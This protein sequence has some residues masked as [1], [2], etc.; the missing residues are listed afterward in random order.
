MAHFGTP[1]L[2]VDLGSTE[3]TNKHGIDL[4]ARVV[5]E[6]GNEWVYVQANGAIVANDVVVVTSAFQADQIDT[7]NSATHHGAVAVSDKAFADN[8]YGWVQ[9]YGPC[10]INVGSSCAI[11]AVLNSTGTAGRVDDDATSGAEVIEGLRTTA[12][13]SS[14]AATAFASY[15]M[16]GVTL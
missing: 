14:N 16:L 5:D 6:T 7:T 3:S 13:E 12:A 10:T 15:P 4:G 2:G 9:I 1:M 11:R 8:E